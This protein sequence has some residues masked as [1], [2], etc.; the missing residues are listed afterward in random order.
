MVASGR[1]WWAAVAGLSLL[2]H[3]V[4]LYWP[5]VTVAGPVTWTDK[6][7]HV[8]VFAVPTFLV[9][10]VAERPRWTTLAFA[11]HAPVSELTQHFLLPGRSG[12]PWDFVADLTGV[13]LGAVALVVSARSLR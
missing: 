7:V 8:L 2:V 1:R 11:A 4:A 10:R 9:G 13:V 6:V 12:D 5:V 3:V